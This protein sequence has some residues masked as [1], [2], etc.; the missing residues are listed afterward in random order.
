MTI[1]LSLSFASFGT[2]DITLLRSVVA[3]VSV[4]AP[5]EA[6]AVSV[7]AAVGEADVVP[8]FGSSTTLCCWA[9]LRTASASIA[10]LTSAARNLMSAS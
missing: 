3:V 9:G 8:T 2:A 5:L 1:R 6:A 7:E 10:S 4:A